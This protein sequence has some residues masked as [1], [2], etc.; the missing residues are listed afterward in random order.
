MANHGD[1]GN[2]EDFSVSAPLGRMATR[3]LGYE[4]LALFSTSV[5]CF[6]NDP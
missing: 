4:R 2:V 1:K 5:A 6:S 3:F